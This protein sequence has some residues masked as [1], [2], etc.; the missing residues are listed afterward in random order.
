V[1]P[2]TDVTSFT[3]NLT[4]LLSRS[5]KRFC[6]LNSNNFFIK[7]VN[8]LKV[9]RKGVAPSVKLAY[10]KLL[11][12]FLKHKS[13]IEWIIACSFWEN[14]FQFSLTEQ[15]E[16]L[17]KGST[18]F[19]SK[20]LE[21][22]IDC[23][24]GFC[25]EV[26]KRIMSPLVENTYR[27]IKAST[28]LGDASDE[29]AS[30]HLKPTLNLIGDILQYFLDGTLFG[31]KDYRVV[32][33]FLKNFHQEGRISNFI[34]IVQWKCLVFDF[35]KIMFIMQF[36]E[37]HLQVV[38]NS[39]SAATL[40]A[41]VC[42]IKNSFNSKLSK[43]SWTD[44][45]E[46]CYFGQFY[47]K[48]IESKIPVVQIRK[49]NKFL[50]F[51][52]QFIILLLMPQFCF[53][54]RYCMSIS[55]FEEE[56]LRDEF[57]DVFILKVIQMLNQDS[58]R[59]SYIWRDYFIARSDVFEIAKYAA[60]VIKNSRRYYSREEAVVVFQAQIYN[61]KDIIGA[62]KDSP[63]ILE[64]FLNKMDYFDLVFETVTLLI[65]EF[66]ITWRDGFEAIDVMA[67]AFDFLTMPH[68]ST[69]VVVQALKLIN[70]ATAKYMT[71]NLALLV[72]LT[73]DS[74]TTF[75][76]PLLYSKFLD[77]VVEVKKAALEV[78]CTMAKMSNSSKSISR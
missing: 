28:D 54:V 75:L 63:E 19:M 17:T 50:S 3:L 71:P 60:T 65:S 57:R 35:G 10:V 23:D 61:L 46:F 44:F 40:N 48:L 30:R 42:R 77:E 68:W 1:T 72:D 37:M 26:V 27:S 74:T 14:V 64:F 22:T 8:T 24:E 31:T 43:G 20:L 55:D 78:T 70:V 52:T 69:Q 53:A 16:R 47:W 18:M 6:C 62:I 11:S 51:S 25:D 67:V 21:T 5:E 41:S 73:A 33:I 38:T 2:P 29:I 7:L 59:I 12:S 36:L 32:L 4:G 9:R 66:D 56:L 45:V 76:G 15:D 39:M 13:G 49:S 58:I 34:N